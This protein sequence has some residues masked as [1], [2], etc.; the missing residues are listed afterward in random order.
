MLGQG[1][2]QVFAQCFLVRIAERYDVSGEELH[3]GLTVHDD[4]WLLYGWVLLSQVMTRTQTRAERSVPVRCSRYFLS[5]K[6]I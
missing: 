3:R 2:A 1:S 6:G 4:Q 5:W